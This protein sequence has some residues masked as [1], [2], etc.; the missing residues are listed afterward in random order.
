MLLENGK[1]EMLRTQVER[2]NKR[3]IDLERENNR[4]RIENIH[5]RS[6]SETVS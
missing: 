1:Y 5:L 6:M 4:L 3:I 2:L